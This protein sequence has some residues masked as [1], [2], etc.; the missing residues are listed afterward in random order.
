MFLGSS[1]N[2]PDLKDHVVLHCQEESPNCDAKVIIDAA[3][4]TTAKHQPQWTQ[5]TVTKTPASGP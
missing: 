2:F 4:A 3:T 5:D 1:Q